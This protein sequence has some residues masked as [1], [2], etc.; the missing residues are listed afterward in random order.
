MAVSP[1]NK[2]A[3]NHLFGWRS[4]SF[5]GAQFPTSLQSYTGVGH[6]LDDNSISLALLLDNV[7]D[8]ERRL[9]RFHIWMASVHENFRAT[10]GSRLPSLHV[11]GSQG[12]SKLRLLKGV[13]DE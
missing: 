9:A 3:I 11:Q 5:Q 12:R 1:Y 7:D 8:A 2:D 6:Q 10:D 13:V 4:E